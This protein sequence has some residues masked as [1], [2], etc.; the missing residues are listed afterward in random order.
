MTAF[1]V[2]LWSYILESREMYLD[3]ISEEIKKMKIETEDDEID[4]KWIKE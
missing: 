2:Y 3:E 1:I 4:A